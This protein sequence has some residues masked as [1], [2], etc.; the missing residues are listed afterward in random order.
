MVQ[1]CWTKNPAAV[2]AYKCK[3]YVKREDQ[4]SLKKD[5]TTRKD[6]QD[7]QEKQVVDV[8]CE[9][10]IKT[11]KQEQRQILDLFNNVF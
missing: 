11:E 10:E 7:V 4:T 6:G 8:K 9:Q 3:P 5:Y 2:F 1:T